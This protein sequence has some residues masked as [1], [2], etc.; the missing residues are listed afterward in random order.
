MFFRRP[1]DVFLYFLVISYQKPTYLGESEFPLP[2]TRPIYW[3]YM[4]DAFEF[5]SLLRVFFLIS[6]RLT[7][8][9]RLRF[10]DGEG[11]L[12]FCMYSSKH[13]KLRTIRDGTIDKGR[14]R[15]FR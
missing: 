11:V 7:K 4:E 15:S 1:R 9:K 3:C 8:E 5:Y 13:V 14:R 2:P 10:G 12:K 6:L